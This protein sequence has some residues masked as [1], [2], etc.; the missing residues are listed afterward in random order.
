MYGEA[1]VPVIRDMVKGTYRLIDKQSPYRFQ[2]AR[3]TSNESLLAIGAD[4]NRVANA[5]ESDQ[6]RCDW[7]RDV[8]CKALARYMGPIAPVVCRETISAAGGVDS[9]DK[10]RRVVEDLAAEI[11]N[12]GDAE[13]FKAEANRE[14]DAG[15]T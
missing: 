1:A 3:P 6:D 5:A 11:G 4:D 2:T 15:T 13:R 10:V 7:V 12:A 14:I 8:L 9:P